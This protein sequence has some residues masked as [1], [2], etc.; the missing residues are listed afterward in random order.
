MKRNDGVTAGTATGSSRLHSQGLVRRLCQSEREVQAF[1]GCQRF[2]LFALRTV[3]SG[4]GHAARK[5]NFKRADQLAQLVQLPRKGSFGFF[6]GWSDEMEG[7]C[8]GLGYVPVT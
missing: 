7:T 1:S 3:L 8:W 5:K 2:N 4:A 6:W